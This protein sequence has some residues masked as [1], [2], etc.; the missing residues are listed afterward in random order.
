[1]AVAVA[2]CHVAMMLMQSTEVTPD[3]HIFHLSIMHHLLYL[4][5]KAIASNPLWSGILGRSLI[6]GAL[7]TPVYFSY[8]FSVAVIN[9]LNASSF[10]FIRI[11]NLPGKQTGI[12][13]CTS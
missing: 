13:K 9:F 2:A 12:C 3:F 6:K 7:K 5:Y 11:S 1:M 8:E 4:D 10:L